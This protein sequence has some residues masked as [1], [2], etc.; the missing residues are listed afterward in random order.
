MCYVCTCVC[1]YVCVDGM[2]VVCVCIDN[3]F[4][5]QSTCQEIYSRIGTPI[6]ASA[7]KGINGIV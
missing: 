5:A 6:I 1:V 2:C 7:L 4:D 3:V